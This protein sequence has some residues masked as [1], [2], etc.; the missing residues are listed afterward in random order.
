MRY[1]IFWYNTAEQKRFETHNEGEI[2]KANS[3]TDALKQWY[4]YIN[5]YGSK[6]EKQQTYEAICAL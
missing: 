2:L 5:A 3:L 1:K 6:F 4:K